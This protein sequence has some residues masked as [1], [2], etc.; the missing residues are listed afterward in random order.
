MDTQLLPLPSNPDA[1]PFSGFHYFK[2]GEKPSQTATTPM[3]IQQLAE[4]PPYF[5]VVVAE[6]SYDVV[7]VRTPFI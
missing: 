3:Y 4:N 7:K 1:K 2:T 5:K 6:N